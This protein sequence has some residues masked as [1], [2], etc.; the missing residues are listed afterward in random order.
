MKQYWIFLVTLI[1]IILDQATKAIVRTV[2]QLH[3][4]VP[5]LGNFLKLTFVENTGMAFGITFAKS[6]FFAVFAAI[7]SLTIL[8]YLY[9]MKGDKLPTRIALALILG[10]ALGNLIDR[11]LYGK[12]VDFID[13]DFF[14]IHLS[15]KKILFFNFPGYYMDRWPV[16]NIADAA[17]TIGMIILIVMVILEK[18]SQKHDDEHLQNHE[19]IV[20]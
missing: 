19:Q 6:G 18:D 16:Y 2:F 8:V 20:R 4:S 7:A 15:A 5:V 14:N 3:E 17:V 1:V 13:S 10:G 9:R 11:V 12:V